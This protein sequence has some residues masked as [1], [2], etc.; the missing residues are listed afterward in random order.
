MVQIGGYRTGGVDFLFV[1]SP[2]PPTPGSINIS[3]GRSFSSVCR[4]FDGYFFF[5]ISWPNSVSF[6]AVKMDKQS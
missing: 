6:E 4:N 3:Q 2:P 5:Y 1:C